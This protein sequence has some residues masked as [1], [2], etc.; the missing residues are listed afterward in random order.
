[1]GLRSDFGSGRLFA[2]MRFVSLALSGIGASPKGRQTRTQA[3]TEVV[4]DIRLTKR[5]SARAKSSLGLTFKPD[6]F[7]AGASRMSPVLIVVVS[8]I[9]TA[10][11]T[12]AKRTQVVTTA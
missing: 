1:M 11:Y 6:N 9:T 8:I 2:V 7:H 3:S 5:A 4:V 10:G 12:L